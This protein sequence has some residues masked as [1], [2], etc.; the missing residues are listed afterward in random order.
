MP[1]VGG[2]EEMKSMTCC[3]S[4]FCLAFLVVAFTPSFAQGATAIAQELPNDPK[5]LMLL[6]VKSNNLHEDDVQPW[7]LKATFTVLDEGGNAIDQGTYEEFWGGAT[8]HKLT[9]VGIGYTRTYYATDK[10]FVHTGPQYLSQFQL[11]AL[12]SQFANPLPRLK[13]IPML[14]FVHKGV[15]ANGAKFACLDDAT[16]QVPDHKTYCLESNN[17]VLRSVYSP[18]FQTQYVHDGIIRFQ[19][20]YVA[21]DL[22]FLQAGKLVLTAHL[23]RIEPLDVTGNED[24]TPPPDAIRS[25]NSVQV[26]EEALDALLIKKARPVYPDTAKLAHVKGPVVVLVHFSPD[27][28]VAAAYVIDGPQLLRE[29]ALDAVRQW[30]IKPFVIK[31]EPVDATSII[32]VFQR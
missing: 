18:T 9:V 3:R 14:K 25:P 32:H 2:S 24:F 19:D 23:D 17:P 6:A 11:D 28:H 31:G 10:G 30:V 20:R 13:A 26:E 22:R 16:P 15:E 5:K 4:L 1:P 7:H 29:A 21:G 27:G 8:K 12:G